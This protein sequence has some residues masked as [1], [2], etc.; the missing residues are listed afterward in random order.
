MRLSALAAIA[1]VF[2]IAAPASVTV[3]SQVAAQTETKQDLVRSLTTRRTRS[4]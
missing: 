1:V 2:G 3:P 4:L